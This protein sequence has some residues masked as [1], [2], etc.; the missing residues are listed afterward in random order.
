MKE[1]ESISKTVSW[2]LY[3]AY[4]NQNI[5]EMVGIALVEDKR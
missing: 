2:E 4:R 3:V 5:Q 1:K